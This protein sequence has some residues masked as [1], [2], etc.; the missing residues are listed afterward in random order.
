MVILVIDFLQSNKKVDNIVTNPPFNLATEF[1]LQS[2]NS[3]NKKMALLCKLSF[4]E[5]LKEENL[6]YLIKIN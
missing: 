6:F 4:L 2:L 3:I 1:T 5:G